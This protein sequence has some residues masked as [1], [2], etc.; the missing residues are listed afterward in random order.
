MKTC[1]L[2]ANFQ[3]VKT[4]N[5]KM[6]V[7]KKSCCIKLSAKHAIN[8]NICVQSKIKKNAIVNNIT[9]SISLSSI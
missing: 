6:V 7:F 3:I 9:I 1:M 8:V 4:A 5:Q 2:A